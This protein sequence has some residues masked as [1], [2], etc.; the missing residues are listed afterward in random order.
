ML[1]G[2]IAT[3][4]AFAIVVLA[5]VGQVDAQTR[6]VAFGDSNTYG[7][8]LPRGEDWP[9]KL[10]VLLKSKGH[11][12]R[13]VNA[14]GSGNTTVDALNRV[15]SAVPAGT[16]I[17]IVTFGVNDARRGVPPATIGK[18]L[19]EIVTRIKSRGTQ[20]I[21]CGRRGPFP[22]GYD[23]EGYRTTIQSIAREQAGRGCNLLDGVPP[24]GFQPDGHENSEGTTVIAGRMAMIVEPLLKK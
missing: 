8:G 15:D 22:H 12:V 17:A 9:A 13:V 10:E 2:V 11:D 16:D 23:I 4:M 6:I 24:S 19:S 1:K 21:L 3:A 18:N 20:V 7:Q 5:G 14:G